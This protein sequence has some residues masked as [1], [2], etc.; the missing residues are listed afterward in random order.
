MPN[1]I[2][3]LRNSTPGVRPTVQPAGAPWVNWA[4]LQLGV[5][6]GAVARD[7]IA[8]RYFSVLAAYALGDHVVQGGILYRALGAV[9]PG[10]FN[11]AQWEAL[12]RPGD[13]SGYLPLTGGTLTGRLTVTQGD[14]L[15]IDGPEGSYRSIV[16]QTGSVMRWR[17][18]LGDNIAEPAGSSFTI[19]RF[20]NSGT[21][22]DTALQINRGTGLASFSGLITA[23]GGV[24][25]PLDITARIITGTS[26][27]I[28]PAIT[29]NNNGVMRIEGL[30][31]FNKQIRGTVNG[32][33][34]WDLNL[35][36]ITPETGANAGANFTVHSYDD[37]ST[38]ASPVLLGTPLSIERA[39]GVC[40]FSA[41]IVTPSNP[42]RMKNVRSVVDALA[43]VEQIDGFYYNDDSGRRLIGLSAEDLQAVL[44]EVVY[45]I[46]P[47]PLPE[48]DP[49]AP[50]WPQPAPGEEMLGISLSQDHRAL[51]E[52]AQGTIRE[53][54]GP[55]GGTET[56]NAPFM[57]TQQRAPDITIYRRSPRTAVRAPQQRRHLRQDGGRHDAPVRRSAADQPDPRRRAASGHKAEQRSGR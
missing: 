34:R 36:D 39:T 46:P 42:L 51:G 24:T 5:H 6:D 30:S 50:P 49:D 19:Q 55:R 8:V 7:L 16:G 52:R 38:G 4:D 56:M 45:T 44:P 21:F 13:L 33:L 15:V 27:I 25:S 9:A 3:I 32:A 2:R 41:D 26:T 53:S 11:S 18:S 57:P 10:A 37:S 29:A 35:G 54:H 12:V 40:T 17:V 31:G 47:A 48:P 43:I 22:I 20:D 14:G 1:S 23:A 28:S